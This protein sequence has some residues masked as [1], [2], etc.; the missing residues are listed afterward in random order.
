MS[1]E[2]KTVRACLK[3]DKLLVRAGNKNPPHKNHD[4]TITY[5]FH[6]LFLLKEHLHASI[7]SSLY[8]ERNINT[9]MQLKPQVKL[10]EIFVECLLK[11][12]DKFES[13]WISDDCLM[14]VTECSGATYEPGDLGVSLGEAP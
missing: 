2:N 13:I 12:L 1:L 6:I 3:A 5:I 10:V 14:Y 7:A 8:D 9:S 4:R 11:F